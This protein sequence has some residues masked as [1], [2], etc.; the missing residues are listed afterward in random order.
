MK[1]RVKATGE[2]VDIAEY[3]TNNLVKVNLVSRHN[4]ESGCVCIQSSHLKKRDAA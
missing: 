2:I 4:V 3:S 1:A